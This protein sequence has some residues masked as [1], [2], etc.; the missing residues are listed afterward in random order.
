MTLDDRKRMIVGAIRK[1]EDQLI[2][3]RF[4]EYDGAK[5]KLERED[6]IYTLQKHL[7]CAHNVLVM[8]NEEECA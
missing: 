2:S 4:C 8:L 5:T 6:E 7:C 3:L 1:L